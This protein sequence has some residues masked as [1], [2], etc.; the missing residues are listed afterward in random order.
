MIRE[1]LQQ[2]I[3]QIRRQSSRAIRLTLGQEKEAMPIHVISTYAPNSGHSEETRQQHWQEVQELLNKTSKQNIA[4]WGS[5]A[6]GQL[7]SRGQVK[8]TKHERQSGQAQ[9]IIGP[10]ARMGNT[11]K[12]ETVQIYREYAGD[13]K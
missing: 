10:Y 1:S 13:S 3:I 9:N 7:G 5:D 4:I 6:N 8:E 11:E 2:N 12:K